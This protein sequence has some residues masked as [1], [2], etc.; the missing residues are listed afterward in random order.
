[1]NI[2]EACKLLHGFDPENVKKIIAAKELIDKGC[3]KNMAADVVGLGYT[4]LLHSLKLLRLR[5]QLDK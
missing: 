3:K 2:E 5:Q 1:M 4:Y